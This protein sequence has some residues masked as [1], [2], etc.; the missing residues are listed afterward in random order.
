M[1]VLLAGAGALW[2]A[3][4]MKTDPLPPLPPPSIVSH[5]IEPFLEVREESGLFRFRVTGSADV[6]AGTVLR[7]RLFAVEA[8][9]D[10]RRG[11]REDEEPLVYEEEDE[12]PPWRRFRI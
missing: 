4:R 7:A 5:P 8:V 6:P 12:L 9:S 11:V 1:G 3:L 2:L 10:F